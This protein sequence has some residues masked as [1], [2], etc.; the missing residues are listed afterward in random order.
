VGSSVPN[1]IK[2]ILLLE[3]TKSDN[4]KNFFSHQVL[5]ANAEFSLYILSE[6]I[7][8]A[9]ILSLISSFQKCER[10][11]SIRVLSAKSCRH[12]Q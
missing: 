8:P 4:Q 12:M 11:S 3:E 5:I 10:D 9:R 2:S 7:F 6:G 1:T